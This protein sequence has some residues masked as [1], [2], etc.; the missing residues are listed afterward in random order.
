LSGTADSEGVAA[1]LCSGTL[2]RRKGQLAERQLA[3]TSACS[4]HVRKAKV[5]PPLLTHAH[6]PTGH[7]VHMVIAINRSILPS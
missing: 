2:C 3:V 4:Q 6:A 5:L 7:K 1:H